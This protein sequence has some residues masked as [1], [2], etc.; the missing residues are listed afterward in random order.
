MQKEGTFWRFQKLEG[1]GSQNGC[2]VMMS[3]ERW[4]GSNLERELEPITNLASN[5]TKKSS[6]LQNCGNQDRVVQ[7]RD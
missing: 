7:S 5:F 1:D 3:L 2:G 4:R 6:R